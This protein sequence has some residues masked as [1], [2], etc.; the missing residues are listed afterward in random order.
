MKSFRLMKGETA[1]LDKLQFPMLGQVKWDG[2]RCGVTPERGPI[3]NTLKTLPNDFI[4]ERIAHLTYHDGE[5][6]TYTDG[7]IDPLNV[8]QSKVMSKDGTPDFRFMCFDHFEHVKEPYWKR[9]ER[10]ATAPS[11]AV[12]NTI[13][14]LN[15]YEESIVALGHE[16]I[17]LRCPNSPYKFGKATVKEN[18]LLKIKRMHDME[19]IVVGFVELMLNENEQTTDDRGLAKRSDSKNGKVPGNT[20][21][22]MIILLST[23]ITF[24]LGGGLSDELRLEI[25]NNKMK[26]L[27]Q[28]VTFKYQR[29]GPNGK[30]L[31]PVFKAFR[32]RDDYSDAR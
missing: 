22:A 24:E 15:H 19:G 20:L 4:R 16:G 9:I 13:E 23:G 21:G 26:Y 10:L 6:I 2:I 28:I 11:Y 3:T 17:M 5:I 12:I 30:P 29:I 8:V 1:E 27:T 18:W 7:A 14:D 25:W 32:H 31:L